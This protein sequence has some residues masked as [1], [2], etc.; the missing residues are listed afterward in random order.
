MME[1]T[2]FP[3]YT[4]ADVRA[5]LPY[6]AFRQ[7]A[8]LL[9]LTQQEAARLLFIPERTR[10]RRRHEGRFT[11]AESD[12]LVR[13]TQLIRQAADAFNGHLPEAVAWLTTPKTLLGDETPLQHADTEPG[14][15]DVRDMLSVIQYNAAA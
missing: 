1:R 14:L 5:G 9:D 4:S 8:N 13:L 2:T 15:A 12:R 10:V 11:Q 7:F 6:D 3:N